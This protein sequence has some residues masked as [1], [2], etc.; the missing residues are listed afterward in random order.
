ME[1]RKIGIIGT[2]KVAVSFATLLLRKG[3]QVAFF[4]RTEGAA[5]EAAAKTSSLLSTNLAAA[6]LSGED[7]QSIAYPIVFATTDALVDWCDAVGFVVTDGA[8]AEVARSLRHNRN[9]YVFHMSGSLSTTVFES[10]EASGLPWSAAFSLHPL[11]SFA[12]PEADFDQIYFALELSPLNSQES[13]RSIERFVGELTTLAVKLDSEQKVLYHASAVIASNLF[14]ALLHYANRQLRSIGI[15]RED[16]LWPLV[17]STLKNMKRFG[18]DASLTGPIARGDVATVE[19]HLH[20]LDPEQIDIYCSLSREALEL[21]NADP[22]QKEAIAALL[23]RA[24][25]SDSEDALAD[26][27]EAGEEK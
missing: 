27:K 21:S 1:I 19:S 20:A 15:E 4:G 5:V 12:K 6:T 11:K 9:R 10:Q 2:G 8:I 22:K 3:F 16:L 13:N 17:D 7:T 14:V 26:S 18:V 25:A 24:I 23:S